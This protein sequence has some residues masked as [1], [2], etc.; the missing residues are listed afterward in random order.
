MITITI[1][2]IKE[3]Y[4]IRLKG[5]ANYQPGNDIVCAAVSA[6]TFALA[7]KAVDMDAEEKGHIIERQIEPGDTRIAFLP[8][9]TAEEE[10]KIALSTI[11][12]G[13]NLIQAVHPSNVVVDNRVGEIKKERC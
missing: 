9:K 5:H 13:Y 11:V 12:E 3:V 2:K 1:Q 7:Q 10:W 4:D 8:G 6:L